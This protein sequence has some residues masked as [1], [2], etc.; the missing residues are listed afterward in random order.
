LRKLLFFGIL[1]V[2]S[3]CKH[4]IA[5]IECKGLEG[6]PKFMYFKNEHEGFIFGS[7]THYHYEGVSDKELA[8]PD[9]IPKYTNE[10]A[11]FKT[12][13]GG[14]SWHKIDSVLNASFTDIYD[15]DTDAIYIVLS[16]STEHFKNN[17][18]KFDVSRNRKVWSDTIRTI[19]SLWIQ[20]N[21]L[22]YTSN[23]DH[24]KLYTLN[25]ELTLVD[26]SGLDFYAEKGVGVNNNCFCI[27][28]YHH[29]SSLG[30]I[31]KGVPDYELPLPIQ[32][33]DIII[34]K[35]RL[36]LAGM[37]KTSENTMSLMGMDVNTLKAN[38]IH[39]F[40]NYSIIRDLHSNE[41]VISA[42][43]GNIRGL[44][45]DYDLWFSLDKG[46]TWQICKL[47]E[48]NMISPNFLIGNILYIYSGGRM[49]KIKFE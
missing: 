10:A 5:F 40:P 11:I 44:G 31:I 8:N 21:N 43:L 17:V 42:F 48:Q 34:D 28:D 6:D 1:L 30:Q 38:L 49:Q 22:C 2:I 26:S 24:I 33:Q 37:E 27:F 35:N 45:V 29:K 15:Y 20:K 23:R 19:S 32:P 13:D 4:N 9:F 14:N 3:A 16:N 7:I 46:K 12:S 41:K 39:Q 18:L 25:E 47:R 36:I